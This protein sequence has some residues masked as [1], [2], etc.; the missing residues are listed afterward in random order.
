MAVYTYSCPSAHTQQHMPPKTEQKTQEQITFML[1]SSVRSPFIIPSWSI[2]A[3]QW[4]PFDAHQAG[5]VLCGAHHVCCKEGCLFTEFENG[6]FVCPI[7]AYCI[8]CIR[9]GSVPEFTSTQTFGFFSPIVDTKTN[10]IYQHLHELI[11]THVRR[12]ILS[13]SVVSSL[14]K[15][16]ETKIKRRTVILTRLCR[17][18]KQCGY[19]G[20]TYNTPT[21]GDIAALLA[22]KTSNARTPLILSSVEANRVCDHC[23]SI[24]FRLLK[25]LPCIWKNT[26]QPK[27]YSLVVGIVYMMRTGATFNNTTLLPRLQILTYILCHETS[28]KEALNIRSK[29]VTEVENIFKLHIRKLS[30]KELH[31]LGELQYTTL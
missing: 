20:E 11:S 25:A 2:H 23:I 14:V 8:P 15:E 18:G 12:T 4:E 30:K 31:Q 16:Y 27:F 17:D 21:M 22:H 26:T 24:I 28:M 9:R 7:T 3:H 29:T 10:N 19:Q 13:D 5:C 1:W 6:D